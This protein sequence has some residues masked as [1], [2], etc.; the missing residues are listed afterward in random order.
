MIGSGG[1]AFRIALCWA[2]L[3]ASP[4][5]AA[6]TAP[7]TVGESIY[8]RGILGSGALLEGA[9]QAGALRTQGADAACVNCHQRSGLGSTHLSA[10]LGSNAGRNSIP[11]IAGRYL[12]QPG[13]PN[14]PYVDGMRT[15]HAAY[16]TATLARAIREGVDSDGKPLSYLMPR[17]G[18]NDAD[19]AALIDYLKSL[20]PAHVPGVTDTT[21]HFATII[22]PE[23][24]PVKRAGMLDVMN[25]YFA[26]R[27]SRQM[28][29]SRRLQAS[30]KTQYSRTMFMVHRQWQLHVWDLTGPAATWPSQLDQHLAK[31]PVFAVI[32]GLGGETW[33]PVHE[34][35]QHHAVPC[36][37]PNVEVPVDSA[38][39]FYS[40]Y[41]SRGV[42]LEAGVIA[43]RIAGAGAGGAVSRNVQQIYRAGDSGGPAA[44]ELAA[45]LKRHG[46]AVRDHVLPA[47]KGGSLADA[48]RSA[49]GADA[50][51]LWL[52]PADLEALGEPPPAK[53]IFASGLMGGLEHA[54]LPAG[55]RARTELAYPFDLPQRR[56]VQVDYPLGWF[57][58]RHIAVVDE[59]VQ[60]DTYLACGLLS[61]ALSHMV[62]TFE[63]PY[64]IEQL[65]S[66]VEH[67]NITGYYPRLTLAENQHFASKGGYLVRFEGPQGT[68]IIDDGGWIVP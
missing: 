19:M 65:Q 41:F 62:D 4:G 25:K 59:Q 57:R 16:T 14:L 17:Y 8:L 22:T 45:E 23:A 29:P 10:G 30:G 11:P 7:G 36:L 33:A 35:C 5:W 58:I 37:F 12:F 6:G 31:E 20:A 21:L 38:K 44:R 32:S 60:T 9:R 27:N 28:N 50:L 53:A 26:E 46:I 61:E 34:F 13:D 63:R 15:Q 24:D 39:D 40:L 52:R 3:A 55:W 18:L 64:L 43:Q 42:L 47:A 66:M 54:P 2:M 48:L 1:R 56:V 51:V 49:A 67:R 68:K